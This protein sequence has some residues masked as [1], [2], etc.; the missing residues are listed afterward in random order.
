MRMPPD[1]SMYVTLGRAVGHRSHVSVAHHEGVMTSAMV[2]GLGVCLGPACV[3]CCVQSRR[4][5]GRVKVA[6]RPLCS[7]G[8]LCRSVVVFY[9]QSDAL[10]VLGH[11]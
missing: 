2:G 4:D 9:G 3:E 11:G 6:S 7:E 5:G 8:V 10:Q 1:L